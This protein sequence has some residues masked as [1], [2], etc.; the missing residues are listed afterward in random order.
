MPRAKAV[1]KCFGAWE[2]PPW[3]WPRG[4]GRRGHGSHANGRVLPRIVPLVPRSAA[5]RRPQPGEQRHQRQAE[6]R[7][8]VALHPREQVDAR[9]FE[10]VAADA[11]TDPRLA[12]AGEVGLDPLRCEGAHRHP[13]R[14]DEDIGAPV[15]HQGDG[16]MQRMGAPREPGQMLPR[17][18][19]GRGLVEHRIVEGEHLIG[20]DHHPVGMAGGDR[21]GLGAGQRLRE[22]DG[23]ES[24]GGRLHRALIDAGRFRLDG[25]G[26]AF[27]EQAPRRAGRGEEERCRAEPG[28]GHRPSVTERFAAARGWAVLCDAPHPRIRTGRRGCRWGRYA[29]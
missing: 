13:C 29:T 24:G 21:L 17:G 25:Q 28:G 1:P 23:R 3:E 16:G 9:P 26:R 12:R 14:L 5:A 15:P 19:Q 18:I 22:F 7:A 4:Y 2:W 27:E 8:V 6:D 11:G 20:A 10:L